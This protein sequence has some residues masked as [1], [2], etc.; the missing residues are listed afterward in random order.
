MPGTTISTLLQPYSYESF[1]GVARTLAYD[2]HIAGANISV[3]CD[4]YDRLL[5]ETPA[6]PELQDDRLIA[7]RNTLTS[8]SGVVNDLWHDVR[9]VFY[10]IPRTATLFPDGQSPDARNRSRW[11]PY[12]E[13]AWD[14]F[15]REVVTHIAPYL[16]R[17]INL[18]ANIILPSELPNVRF[19]EGNWLI[20]ERA[21]DIIS[22]IDSNVAKLYSYLD[23]DLLNKAYGIRF[24]LPVE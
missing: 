9:W 22:T 2:I 20:Q 11:Q 12:D 6:S 1:Y 17:I 21:E 16:D 13:R 7:F 24:D 4:V 23:T 18:R 5:N 14:D 19:G 15:Y 3:V 8:I 10:R